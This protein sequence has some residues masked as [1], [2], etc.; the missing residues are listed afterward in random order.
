MRSHQ[1]DSGTGRQGLFVLFRHGVIAARS[2]LKAL[3]LVRIQYPEPIFIPYGIGSNPTTGTNFYAYKRQGRDS[4]S[5][6]GVCVVR[7]HL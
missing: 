3:V 4:V 1:F 2:S 6:A 7:L 5:Y